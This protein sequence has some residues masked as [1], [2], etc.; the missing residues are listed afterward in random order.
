MRGDEKDLVGKVAVVTGAAS[1]IGRAL[2]GALRAA[3]AEVVLAD[4]D[5]QRLAGAAGELDAQGVVVDVSRCADMR[6]LG[7]EV[8]ERHGRVDLVVNNA[9]IARIAPFEELS[10]ADWER[11]LGVNLWGTVHG[12]R[13]FLPLL[14]R[15]GGDGFLVNTA[16]IAGVRNGPGLSAYSASKF[17]VV[18]LTETVAQEL[19]G[20][21]SR[22]GVGVV[23][24]ARVRTG[25]TGH[26]G[27]GTPGV[28]EAEDVART[29][30]EGIRCRDLY[31][32]THPEALESVRERHRRIEA[33]F[34]AAADRESGT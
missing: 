1:G 8:M 18:T 30:L 32:V 28:L 31:I 19:A 25:M 12:M 27:A 21:G 26:A 23:L 2:A 24:P 29:V 16:S 34:E 9:G 5:E 22:V 15:S 17:G 4:R 20:S 7:D 13:V 6:R 14:E 3:G 33:A 10:S 11:T